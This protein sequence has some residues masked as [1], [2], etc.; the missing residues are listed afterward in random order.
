M[1]SE[2]Q[3]NRVDGRKYNEINLCANLKYLQYVCFFIWKTSTDD[4]LNQGNSIFVKGI[5][6]MI[7]WKINF[8]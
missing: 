3:A 2:M 4:L 1:F 7:Y 6:D 8:I 5:N